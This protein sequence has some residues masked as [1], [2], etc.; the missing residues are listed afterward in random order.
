ML[1]KLFAV[2][3]LEVAALLTVNTPN[4]LISSV[5]NSVKVGIKEENISE[6]ELAI[7]HTLS[8]F[9]SFKQ[10]LPKDGNLFESAKF[11]SDVEVTKISLCVKSSVFRYCTSASELMLCGVFSCINLS[12]SV[13]S[14]T[15]SLSIK[16]SFDGL[17]LAMTDSTK[18]ILSETFPFNASEKLVDLDHLQLVICISENSK[19]SVDI[20][21]KNCV[22]DFDIGSLD[23]LL[24][25]VC[26]NF[27]FLH[28]LVVEICV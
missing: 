26:Y 5:F 8:Q 27:Y 15:P 10:N 16:T 13:L 24:V 3:F 4:Q 20:D 19:T 1:F 2:W 21:F 22:I 18:S 9:T 11:K 17:Q 6:N 28:F 7:L 14:N 23:C 12:T 25:G